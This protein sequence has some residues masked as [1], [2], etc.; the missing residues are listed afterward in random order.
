MGIK[1]EVNNCVRKKYTSAQ[2]GLNAKTR[3]QNIRSAFEFKNIHN[4]KY[5]IIFDDV[6]TTGSTM[7]ELAKEIKSQG[8][9]RVDV[10]SLARAE[11]KFK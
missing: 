8:V 11:K 7:N 1:I 4:Y 5:I 6:M 2:T 9:E 3:K 10:W